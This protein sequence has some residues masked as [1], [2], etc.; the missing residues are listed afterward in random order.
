MPKKY[1]G[2][3]D[4]ITNECLWQLIQD[5]YIKRLFAIKDELSPAELY[6]KKGTII[7]VKEIPIKPY[8]IKAISFKVEKPL[9]DN[10]EIK[11]SKKTLKSKSNKKKLNLYKVAEETD[12]KKNLNYLLSKPRVFTVGINVLV[13]FPYKRERSYTSTTIPVSAKLLN[14]A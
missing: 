14:K 5:K 7:S 2:C 3:I 11:N 8:F 4:N 12:H 10:Q 6:Y 9:G 1:K 13:N